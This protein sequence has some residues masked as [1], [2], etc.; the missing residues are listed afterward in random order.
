M[1]P[2]AILKHPKQ[3]KTISNTKYDFKATQ[4]R[5]R[6]L[7]LTVDVIHRKGVTCLQTSPTNVYFRQILAR[8]DEKWRLIC[9]LERLLIA[10]LPKTL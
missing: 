2:V 3:K 4:R 10:P 6:N 7:T 8:N 9:T 5:M 1:L